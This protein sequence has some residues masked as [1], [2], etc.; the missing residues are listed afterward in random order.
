MA[1]TSCSPVAHSNRIQLTFGPGV[2]PSG[3]GCWRISRKRPSRAT[4]VISWMS[5]ALPPV[6]LAQVGD[7]YFVKDGHHRISVARALGQKAIEAKVVVWQVEGSLPWEAATRAPGCEP[8]G[9]PLGVERAFS[10]LRGESV[11]LSARGL[12]SVV[13]TALTSPVRSYG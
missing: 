1:K 3:L 9:Q 12:L 4:W 2:N 7:I 11:L 8:A 6:S 5:K 13:R 10:K